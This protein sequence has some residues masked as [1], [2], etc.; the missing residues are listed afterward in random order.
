MAAAASVQQ[1]AALWL[2]GAAALG[3]ARVGVHAAAVPTVLQ[4]TACDTPPVEQIP[5]CAAFVRYSACQIEASWSAMDEAAKGDFEAY[6]TSKPLTGGKLHGDDSC[7]IALKHIYCARHFSVCE[8]GSPQVFCRDSCASTVNAN[9]SAVSSSVA[10]MQLELCGDTAHPVDGVTDSGKCFGV[11][12]VG[13]KHTAWIIGFSIAV[14]FSF[15]A[16]VGINLQKKAL[17]QNELA[18]LELNGEPKPVYRLPM[19][20]L[21]FFL[22]LAGSILDFVAFGMAPQ[23]LLA[24]LAA[25]TLVW[26][27][28]LAPCFNK[29]KLSRKDI[30]ATLVIF[31]GATIAVVFASHASP[32]YN[33]QMLIELYKDPLTCVYFGVV[34]IIVALH[35]GAIQFVEK[36]SLTSRRHRIIQ[37][38]QPAFW[39]RVRLI[40]YSGLAGTMGGQSVLFAKSCAE[41]LKSAFHG[42]NC[43][44]HFQTYVIAAALI[45]C[46][47]CQIHFLNCGL[48]HFDALS[49]VPIYQAYW[50]ISGVMG[51]AIYF[52][53]IRSF[54]IHQACMFVL[55]ITTTIFGVVLLS[56]RKPVAQASSSTLKRKNTLER[57]VSYSSAD[58]SFRTT[59]PLPP[60]AEVPAAVEAAEEGSRM[61][62]MS[63]IVETEATTEESDEEAQQLGEDGD[64]QV[65]RQVI[66][67]YLDM[68]TSMGITEI[69]AG[70]G[71]Q[72]GNQSGIFSRRPSSRENLPDVQVDRP[73]R[74]SMDDIEV[75][76][77]S[78]NRQNNPRGKMAKRRS[79]TFTTFQNSQNPPPDQ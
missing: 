53:E 41:L 77:P 54:S 55:G 13:P 28:M 12:Y 33:L 40:A 66:D 26:N 44:A 19:W 20:C 16:S 15:L 32:S 64:D 25:L 58:G 14:V 1:R 63:T 52:Q 37:M 17:K 21:G 7:A 65:S 49:V 6:Q 56:Q 67:N 29:E 3:C 30:A 9:C 23:S 61:D 4:C 50:I 72:S 45:A 70:L 71:F 79:I 47:L 74:R 43:F 69:L 57:G 78:A 48:L 22:I 51:G 39:S 11:D 5:F 8:L 38:G 24:P 35:Y 42:D 68:T 36:L 2:L 31:S 62:S 27:M 18:A 73:S 75:G 46:L 60:V 76:L 34:A 59:A 10:P